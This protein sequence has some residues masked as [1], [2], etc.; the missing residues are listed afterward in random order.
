MLKNFLLSLVLGFFAL[1]VFGQT[2]TTVGLTQPTASNL[3]IGGFKVPSGYVIFTPVQVQGIPI[4]YADYTGSQNGPQG[5]QCQ[6]TNGVI[7]GALTETGSYSGLCLLSDASLTVPANILYQAQVF[8]TSVI[9]RT[10]QVKNTP[11]TPQE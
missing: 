8:D 11:H 5:F 2:N 1:P 10:T 4:V 3:K 7:G 9:C 6:V